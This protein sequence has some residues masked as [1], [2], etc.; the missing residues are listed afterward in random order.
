M[1]LPAGSGG[2]PGAP[3]DPVGS[4]LDVRQGVLERVKME[5]GGWVRNEPGNGVKAEECKSR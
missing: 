3:Q 4:T 1:A 5:G 2:P